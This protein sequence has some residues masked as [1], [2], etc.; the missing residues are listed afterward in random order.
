MQPR[1]FSLYGAVDLGARQ[2]IN[3]CEIIWENRALDYTYT[4]KRSF[5]LPSPLLSSEDDETPNA[6]CLAAFAGN[7][8]DP[9]M[10]VG[11]S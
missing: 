4:C 6:E 3:S 9:Q 2:T 1:D 11:W 7:S 5:L 8:C 10:N